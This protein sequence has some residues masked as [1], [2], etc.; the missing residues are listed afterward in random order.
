V[1][2]SVAR[3]VAV[4]AAGLS[5]AAL[6]AGCDVQVRLDGGPSSGPLAPPAALGSLTVAAESHAGSYRRKAFGQS[7]KDLD[8]NGCGQRDDVL[9]RDLTD[10]RKRTRCVV[11][12]GTLVDPYT[13]ARVQFAKERAQEVQIDH[14]VALAEAWRSGAW[15]WPDA[16]REQFANDLRNLA[17]SEGSVNQ[18]KGDD[19][20][21][22]WLPVGPVRQCTFARQVITVKAAYA[23]TVDP[24]EATALRRA[25]GGCPAAPKPAP[26]TP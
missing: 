26:T 18:G 20:A 10:V 24:D 3:G 1:H 22:R 9:A 23:L 19:D 11:V 16:R 5:A 7:W 21:A 14:R 13:G 6:L 12:A 15:A 4:L 17:A 25:L 8:H 2:P